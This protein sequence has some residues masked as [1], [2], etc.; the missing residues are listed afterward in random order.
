[1]VY[2]SGEIV[3]GFD[4]IP[5]MPCPVVKY[6]IGTGPTVG[7][8]RLHGSAVC[9]HSTDFLPNDYIRLH[10]QFEVFSINIREGGSKEAQPFAKEGDSGALV[11]LISKDKTEIKL[12]ALGLLVGGTD[13]GTTIVTP[14]WA[15]LEHLNLPLNMLSFDGSLMETDLSRGENDRLQRIEKD[16]DDLKAGV[17]TLYSRLEETTQTTQRTEQNIVFMDRKIEEIRTSVA[18]KQDIETILQ[19]LSKK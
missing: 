11:F 9:K 16:V 3:K 5:Q 8:L 2:T 1:M 17:S 18:N 14:I 10:Q 12:K 4:E 19:V 13:N 15:I 7:M 6:G